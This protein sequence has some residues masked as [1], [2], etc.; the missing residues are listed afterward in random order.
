[1]LFNCPILD[2]ISTFKEFACR[3]PIV[4]PKLG[5]HPLF[6]YPQS[7]WKK[8]DD[9]QFT[10]FLIGCNQLWLIVDNLNFD[11]PTLK[12]NKNCLTKLGKVSALLIWKNICSTQ[13]RNGRDGSSWP[14]FIWEISSCLKK[15][16]LGFCCVIFWSFWILSFIFPYIWFYFLIYLFIFLSY[17]SNFILFFVF[18]LVGTI[19]L[20]NIWETRFYNG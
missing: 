14:H 6:F 4:W 15:K 9:I 16:K 10:T 2:V 7:K 8:V 20:I 17:I 18:F 3:H 12:K 5:F 13:V 11:F 1:M 19:K